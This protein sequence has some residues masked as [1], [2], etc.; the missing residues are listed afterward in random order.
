MVGRTG[1]P[2]RLRLREGSRNVVVIDDDAMAK[3]DNGEVAA[4]D[5]DNGDLDD[6]DDQQDG[7]GDGPRAGPCVSDLQAHLHFAIFSLNAA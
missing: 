6:E 1:M 3:S 4:L 5:N 2:G 7:G